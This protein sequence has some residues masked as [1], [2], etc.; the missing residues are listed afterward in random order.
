MWLDFGSWQ[1]WWSTKPRWAPPFYLAA[2]P[3]YPNQWQLGTSAICCATKQ[4]ALKSLI[5]RPCV[6]TKQPL[7]SWKRETACFNFSFESLNL[8][9]DPK[10]WVNPWCSNP[11][12]NVGTLSWISPISILDLNPRSEVI[13]V[14]DITVYI[15]GEK[16][17]M[18][19]NFSFPCMTIV[20]KLKFFPQ[21][22]K[23]QYNWLDFIAIYAVLWLNRL[24]FTLFCRK[25]FATIYALSCGEKLSP[26]VHMWRKMTN[27]RSVHDLATLTLVLYL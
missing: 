8:V 10:S 26:K 18:W 17:V 12:H 1:H 11:P 23:F 16:I 4:A 5:L 6:A 20:G 2:W 19:R 21:A 13:F 3:H 9:I 15:C 14:T 7:P 22:E 27:I 25:F 24:I